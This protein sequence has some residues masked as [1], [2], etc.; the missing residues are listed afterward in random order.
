MSEADAGDEMVDPVRLR[1]LELRVLEIDVV[2]DLGD[3]PERV[4]L[5]AE[6]LDEYLEGATVALMCVFRFE[7][8][9]THF[10]SLRPVSLACDELEARVRIDEATDEPGAGHPIDVNPLPGDPG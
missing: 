7:H 5:E 10:T 6:P 1:Q 2:H 8:V 3:R 9:E 4:I